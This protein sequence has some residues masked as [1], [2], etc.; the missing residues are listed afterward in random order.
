MIDVLIIGAGSAGCVLADR[1]SAKGL[2]VC[3]VEAG[4]D[5]RPDATP[6]SIRGASFFE[7][8]AE[9][10]RSYPELVAQRVVGQARRP[11]A[12]GRG[13]G[14]SSAVNAMIGLWGEI[15][16]YDEWERDFGCVGWSWRE[17]EKYFHRIEVPL[18]RASPEGSESVTGALVDSCIM[19]GWALHRGPFPLSGVPADVGPAM[20]TR[21][22]N[23]RR[24]TAADVYLERARGRGNV[25]VRVDSVV[26]RVMI[27]RGRA[28]GVVLIDGTE[29]GAREVVVAAGAIHSPAI[30]LRSGL[31]RPGIGEGL[32][33]HP[34]A[35]ITVGLVRPPDPRTLPVSAVAR[36]SSGRQGADLQLLPINHL[37][38]AAPGFGLINV[39]LMKVTSRGKVKLNPVGALLDPVVDFDMLSTDDDVEALT[40][41]VGVLLDLLDGAGMRAIANEFYIDDRGTTVADIADS[42]DAVRSWLVSSTGDYVHAAGTCAMGD[43]RSEFTVVGP[44][45]R[46]VGVD[47][48]RVCDASIFPCVP[49]AN[50]HFPV[51]MAAELIADRW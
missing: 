20:L 10:G 28:T 44:D 49:R 7:A 47:G 24:V 25:E 38:A 21:D 13:V 51:M 6:D 9:P 48:L 45:A 8:L 46:V 19:N 29:I 14:G 43:P 30:L 50:T 31:E 23:G 41:G 11:Y 2:S 34:S 42:P 16:D 36:F 18:H 39:A 37:G 1:L 26:D 17:V 33:D 12:R 40:A 32:Q 15:D 22:A 3:V 4:P 5:L 35:P 27:E